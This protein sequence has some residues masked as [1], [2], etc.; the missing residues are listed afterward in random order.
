MLNMIL[1]TKE[2]MKIPIS[3][4]LLEKI[5]IKKNQIQKIFIKGKIL[6]ILQ[7][8]EQKQKIM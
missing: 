8:I 3:Q 1:T 6:K 7:I 2:N 4:N 5:K